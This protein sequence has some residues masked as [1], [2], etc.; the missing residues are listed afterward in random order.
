[1]PLE[2]VS[3]EKRSGQ[4][5][6]SFPQYPPPQPNPRGI[7]VATIKEAGGIMKLARQMMTRG[8]H[9]KKTGQTVHFGHRNPKKKPKFY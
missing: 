7:P 1:M 8:K 4:V 5:P 6:S 9:S 3:D 2:N